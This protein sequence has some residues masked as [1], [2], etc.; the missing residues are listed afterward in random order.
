MPW[1]GIGV[2]QSM[3]QFAASTRMPALIRKAATSAGECS[4]S[5]WLRKVMAEA[6]ARELGMDVDELVAQ[7][8]Q[9]RCSVTTLFGESR[10]SR[11][12][13]AAKG[14]V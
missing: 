5:A 4:S 9:C 7:Q 14:V 3:V 12:N 2:R 8:P 11:P 1:E 10:Q 13:P 6:V